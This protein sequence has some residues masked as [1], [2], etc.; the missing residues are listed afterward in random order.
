MSAL[1][2][3]APIGQLIRWATKGRLFPYPEE[4]PG[5]QCPADYSGTQKPEPTSAATTQLASPNSVVEK[6]KEENPIDHNA[7]QQAA[8]AMDLEAQSTS[9]SSIDV[10]LS[11]AMTRPEMQKVTTRA[12]LEQAYTNATKQE[13]LKSSRSRP[14]VPEKTSDGTILVDWYSTDDPENPQ[15]WSFR[16]KIIVVTQI[17]FYTLAV[18]IGS[19]II[20]PSQPYIEEIFHVNAQEASMGLSMY[21]LGYGIGPLLF[22][23]LSEIPSI[24]RNPPYMITFGIFVVLSIGTACV[25]NFSGLIAL[26]FFQGFF[27]SPC[28]ATG[29]ASIGDIFNL[30]KLPYYLTGWAAFATAGPALGL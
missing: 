17:Y 11:K 26:R 29:G 16:K 12:D 28:L 2:R 14:I 19:A 4:L 23:P 13:S 18:Y 27:G 5:F 6:E 30:L 1:L 8:T 7:L 15:N 25:D 21:V 22:S 24:G 3:D 10:T 9:S 20:T